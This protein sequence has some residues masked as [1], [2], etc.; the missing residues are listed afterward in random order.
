M[1]LAKVPIIIF[2]GDNIPE[3]PMNDTRPQ[4]EQ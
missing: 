1:L 2:Y 4:D 3:K